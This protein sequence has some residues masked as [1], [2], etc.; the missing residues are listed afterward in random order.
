MTK[1]KFWRSLW[2]A[3]EKEACTMAAAQTFEVIAKMHLD[4]RI[5]GDLVM[6][7]GQFVNSGDQSELDALLNEIATHGQKG[8]RDAA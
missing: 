6:V 1:A 3:D 7:T 5:G 2:L 4:Q 8:P